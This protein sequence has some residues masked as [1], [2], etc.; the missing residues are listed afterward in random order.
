MERVHVFLSVQ[1][2]A[3]NAGSTKCLLSANLNY[4][5]NFAG[6]YLS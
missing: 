1:R 3:C 2:L 4:K 6:E 5:A